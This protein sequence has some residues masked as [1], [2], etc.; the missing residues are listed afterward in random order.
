MIHPW[1]T[2]RKRRP[3]GPNNYSVFTDLDML[4]IQSDDDIESIYNQICF[5]M[6]DEDKYD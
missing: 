1:I 6:E 2:P 5:T 3:P 4:D